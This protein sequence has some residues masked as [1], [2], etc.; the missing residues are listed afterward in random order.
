MVGCMV[1]RTRTHILASFFILYSVLYT[2]HAHARS[3]LNPLTQKITSQICTIISWADSGLLDVQ[4]NKSSLLF[5]RIP[6]ELIV[7]MK[8]RSLSA[9]R[10][11]LVDFGEDRRQGIEN[12]QWYFLRVKTGRRDSLLLQL[13]WIPKHEKFEIMRY[14]VE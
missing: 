8:K 4:P 12:G 11:C 10:S 13:K 1:V 9:L 14:E 6:S 7:E 2:P 5:E 3:Y